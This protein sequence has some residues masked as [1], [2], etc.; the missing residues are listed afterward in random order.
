M[1]RLHFLITVAILFIATSLNAQNKV[2]R[3]L[4]NGSILQSY[5]IENI[6]SI[7]IDEVIDAPSGLNAKV[8]NRTVVL[9]WNSIV[10]ATYDV[11]RSGDDKNYNPIATGITTNQYVDKSPAVGT[12]YYKIKASVGG[13]TSEL[14]ATTAIATI[15]SS[16]LESGIYLGVMSF[17]QGVYSQPISILN[18]TTKPT[19]DAFI[20]AMTMKNGTLLYYSVDQAINTM[21]SVP[22]PDDIS[23]A[24]IVTFTDGLDQGSMMM[25]VPY[26]DNTEYLDALN[27]RIMNETVNGKPI[28]AFSIGIRGQ[29]V[30]DVTMFR[31]NLAKLA[32]LADNATEVTS[33]AEVNA[34]FKEIAE[35][36]SQSNYI[37]TINLTIPGVSNGTLIRFTFDNVNSAEKST[38]YIEGTFNLSTRSLEN[39]KYE[40]MTSTSGTVIKGTVDGIFVSFT[41]EGIHTKNN[42]LIDSKF[43]DEWTYIA[44]NSTWQINSEFDKTENSDIVTERS[45]AVIM[46]VLDCSSSLSNDFVK[47]QTNAKDFI[48]SLYGT[49][50]GDDNSGETPEDDNT[51]YSTTP[52]DLTLAIWKDETRYYLTQEEYKKANL[53]NAII[54]GLCVVSGTN[55]PFVIALKDAGSGSMF[56]GIANELYDL[57]NYD[58]GIVISARMYDINAAL[59]AFGGNVL[60]SGSNG[61]WTS[62]N[63]GSNYFYIDGSGG[64]L[65]YISSSSSSSSTRYVRQVFPNNKVQ[66]PLLTNPQNDLTLAVTNGESRLFIDR[67]EYST[68][69]IPAGYTVEGLAIC[70]RLGNFILK[71]QDE[72]SNSMTHSAAIQ[73][74][75]ETA[76]PNYD[77]GRVI[78]ARKPDI[79]AALEAFGG[80]VLGYGSNG[81]WTSY[82]SG[83]NYYYISLSG[84]ILSYI[85]SSSTRYV[86]LIVGTF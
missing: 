45:S 56:W 60:G 68:N 14:S 83:S 1:K 74:Y 12:N 84:G 58:Q 5:P 34:K 37:Q 65:S 4:Q 78:S 66:T 62:Y 35:Q 54:E 51:I 21:Q 20:D 6:D 13:S 29:D 30:A 49:V 26:N 44:S 76:L 52:K 46:L 77:Q 85:S 36:L 27:R 28:T 53:S 22:L 59:Q 43:T 10:S 19:Y 72:S 64:I 11:Y 18:E 82:N 69:G 17:N 40:G 63:S 79:N 9:T 73:L 48:N 38:L 25:D 7:I 33:M 3:I 71:L 61:T 67:N 8:E 80:N 55:E 23:T 32:S 24:A 47:A 41:F 81:T 15:T 31:N 75:G 2:V 16:D 39:V 50:G 70:S 86:R 57:P 42:K